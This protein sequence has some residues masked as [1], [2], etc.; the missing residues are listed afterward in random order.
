MRGK[1]AIA[2]ANLKTV[3]NIP[4]YAGKTIV[5]SPTPGK[6]SEHPRVCGENGFSIACN[7]RVGG[8]SPRMRG[9]PP[10]TLGPITHARNIPAYAG[11]TNRQP[12]DVR[13]FPE[14]PRVCGENSSY[15]I[16]SL[17]VSG[18]SPRMRGKLQDYLKVVNNRRNIPAYAGKTCMC[19]KGFQK[20]AEHP[21]VCGENISIS[22]ER[23]SQNGTSPRMRG[24]LMAAKID[25]F[26]K[27]N[28]PAYAGKTF[29]CVHAR[30]MGWEHPRVCGENLTPVPRMVHNGGT[31]PRM[32]GKPK[33]V[34]WWARPR[35]NI[36]AYAGKTTFH[37]LNF[38]WKPEHPRVCGENLSF[39]IAYLLSLGTSPRM[40]GKH[41]SVPKTFG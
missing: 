5:T 3:W 39:Q 26:C 33:P 38:C 40:R 1:R 9:K 7:H 21:R 37:E 20:C 24:K 13:C 16:R 10:T 27:R 36:P 23:E 17:C 4:A 12:T 35:R 19:V 32:R 11:K 28:I 22:R 41:I 31:S 18:T 14:H 15:G 6:T 25:I 8:T 30:F 34:I 29:S 2:D